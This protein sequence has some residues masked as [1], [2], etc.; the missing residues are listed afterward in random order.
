MCVCVLEFVH[1]FSAARPIMI[2]T[3]LTVRSPVANHVNWAWKPAAVVV[4]AR[5]PRRTDTSC[6]C[7]SFTIAVVVQIG[8][9]VLH[10]HTHIHKRLYYFLVFAILLMLVFV[11]CSWLLLHS[12]RTHLPHPLKASY[13]SICIYA[14]VFVL[15]FVGPVADPIHIIFR[16][17]TSFICRIF[18]ARLLLLLYF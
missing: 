13:L 9:H 16:P 11:V 4:A 2:S 15:V 18:C 8:T 5:I 10:T 6:E 7:I 14:S 3:L 12:W 1:S 17:V